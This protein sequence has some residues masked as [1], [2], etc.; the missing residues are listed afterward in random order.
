MTEIEKLIAQAKAEHE[1]DIEK[2]GDLKPDQ[3][4]YLARVG[5]IEDDTA[6]LECDHNE[7]P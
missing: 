7:G 2:L 1:K 6:G 4:D 5:E 3:L